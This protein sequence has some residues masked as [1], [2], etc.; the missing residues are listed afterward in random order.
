MN[1]AR[2]LFGIV[3]AVAFVILL[4]T[5]VGA[6]FRSC[7][8]CQCFFVGECEFDENGVGY[9]YRLCRGSCAA[10]SAWWPDTRCRQP[11]IAPYPPLQ[12]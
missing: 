4:F 10:Y 1:V 6:D 2:N 11:L 9:N 7:E 12:P 3:V 5:S 8:N